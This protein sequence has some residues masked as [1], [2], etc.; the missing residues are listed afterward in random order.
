MSMLV[1]EQTR[2]ISLLSHPDTI[3]K[4]PAGVHEGCEK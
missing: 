3:T 1:S 2:A 4:L